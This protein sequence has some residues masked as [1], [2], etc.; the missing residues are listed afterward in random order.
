[1]GLFIRVLR[2]KLKMG[3]KMLDIR[4]LTKVTPE[5]LIDIKV[6]VL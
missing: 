2:T 4:I 1:M 3:Q 5:Q 6:G